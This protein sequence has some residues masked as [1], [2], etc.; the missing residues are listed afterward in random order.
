VLS[1]R[2]V[3]AVLGRLLRS[4]DFERA[5]ATPARV[6]SAHFAAHHVAQEPGG[7]IKLTVAAPAVKLST[8]DPIG[9]AQPVDEAPPRGSAQCWFGCVVPK[10]HARKATTR[11]LL[12]RQIRAAME[13][14]HQ[15]LP[16]GLWLVRL[17]APFESAQYRSAASTR[18]RDAARSE[19]DGL[20]TRAAA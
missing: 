8:G 7:A 3:F 19:L 2:A 13:R 11:N 4:A 14:H 15:G 12:R 17:R 18:L 6:R 20:L 1:A 10:R 5:L 16:Q 9:C